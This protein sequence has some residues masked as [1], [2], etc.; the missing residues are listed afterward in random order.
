MK[1]KL[2]NDLAELIDH[3]V[4]SSE[5]ANR[6]N[7]YYET[8]RSNQSNPL[9]TIFGI[10][11]SALVGLGIILILAHNWDDF[12]RTIKTVFAFLPLIIGQLLSSYSILKNKSQA[13]KE[14]SG[15]FLFFAI[16][17]SIALVSQVYNIPGDLSSY[18][19]TW[20]V[21]GLP[22]IYVLNSKAV[23]IF[24]IGFSTYYA[25]EYGYSF[26]YGNKSPWLYFVLLIGTIPFYFNELKKS[27]K[28]NSTAILNWLY[29]LS[30]IIV[31]GAFIQ[32]NWALGFVMYAMLFGVFYNLGQLEIFN[33]Q[34]LRRNSYVVLGS[35]GS[36]VLLMIL[37]FNV[38]WEEIQ[39]EIIV[40]NSQE[41]WVSIVLI[42]IA[43]AL[44]V[45]SQIPKGK[46]KFNVFQYVFIIFLIVFA[47]GSESAKLG[48]IS[49][50]IMILIFGVFAVKLGADTFR[51]SILNYGL[52]I[53]AT[54]IVCRFFDTDMSFVLR[55]L[56]FVVVG[57]GF[58]LANYIMLKKQKAI[59]HQTLN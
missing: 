48:T 10:L 35:F 22:L 29:A 44:L 7:N 21:L 38:I 5:V 41:M 45:Y 2:K 27:P 33:S 53:I 24:V 46:F 59:K 14:S 28:A 16:G 17:A 31:L 39:Y 12:S 54:A 20:I 26:G 11:G 52:L 57:L 40:F 25:C 58:F 37:S 4:I 34:Q 55:G 1:S 36:V 47:L 42:F 32:N 30:L 6:I 9:F 15:T 18:L 43:L 3:N 19:L 8:K 56:L 50:N 51:F 49:T 23:A 13:W